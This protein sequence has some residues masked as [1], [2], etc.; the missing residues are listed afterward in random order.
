MITGAYGILHHS[1]VYA[2]VDTNNG[3]A[4]LLLTRGSQAEVK[5]LQEEDVKQRVEVIISQ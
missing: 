4:H 1:S 2:Q 3:Y 5:A